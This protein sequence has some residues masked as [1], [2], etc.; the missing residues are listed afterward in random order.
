M[1]RLYSVR[2]EIYERTGIYKRTGYPIVTHTFLGRT[3]KEA[4]HYHDSHRKT[5]D[6]LRQCEDKGQ[7]TSVPCRVLVTEGWT[8]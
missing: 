4:W 5:D 1:A 6:F 2:V 8:A 3:A 7:W